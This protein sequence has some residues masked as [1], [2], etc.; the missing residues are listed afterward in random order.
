M[1]KIEKSEVYFISGGLSLLTASTYG[2]LSAFT[3]IA[4][5][6]AIKNLKPATQEEEEAYFMNQ[7]MNSWNIYAIH[8]FDPLDITFMTLGNN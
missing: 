5:Y 6:Y 7:M 2:T 8:S 1:K 3:L 4:G